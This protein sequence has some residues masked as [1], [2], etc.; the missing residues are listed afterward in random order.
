MLPL[1]CVPNAKDSALVVAVLGLSPFPRNWIV[2]DPSGELSEMV[3]DASI[4]PD[5]VGANVTSTVQPEPGAMRALQ[6][7]EEKSGWPLMGFND[8]VIALMVS[9]CEFDAAFTM[10]IDIDWLLVPTT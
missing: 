9:D 3:I 1:V 7:V 4:S 6:E 2:C 5:S 8:D 10:S